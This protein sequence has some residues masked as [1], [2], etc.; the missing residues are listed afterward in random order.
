MELDVYLSE[1]KGGATSKYA[2][3]H[4]YRIALKHQP[5]IAEDL[6]NLWN[7]VEKTNVLREFQDKIEK[8]DFTAYAV[9]PSNTEPFNKQI[10][11]MLKVQFSDRVDL[12]DFFIKNPTFK[13]I[14]STVQLQDEELKS[15]IYINDSLNQMPENIE[16]VLLVDDIYSMGN[17][18]RAMKIALLKSYPNV[19]IKGAVILKTV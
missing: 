19:N 9:A 18:F 7:R 3:P 14:K 2:I 15:K 16:S 17:T 4:R 5:L 13:A 6:L 11:E 10:R 1:F 8:L 12:S